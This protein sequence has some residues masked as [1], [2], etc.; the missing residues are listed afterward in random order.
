MTHADFL[1]FCQFRDKFK[2]QIEE[3]KNQLAGEESKIREV[4][5]SL[6]T[7]DGVPEYNLENILVYNQALD[8]ITEDD[9]I[10]LIVVGDNPGKA[11][12]LA[13]NQRYFKGCGKYTS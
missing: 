12:Q 1:R 10:K 13:E 9:D 3:W 6:A 11:E 8:E 4:Q 2:N 5:K 7:K